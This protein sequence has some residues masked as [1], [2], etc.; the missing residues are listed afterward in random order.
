M[1]RRLDALAC[2]ALSAAALAGCGSAAHHGAPL[3]MLGAR[4]VGGWPTLGAGGRGIT[5]RFIE[6]TRLGVGLALRNRS[7]RSVTVVDVRTLE[8]PRTI[9]H[10]I[11]TRLVRWDPPSCPP[12]VRG[13]IGDVFSRSS[14]GAVRPVP[15]T[16]PPGKDVGVQ[17]N[18]RLGSCR[19]V[20]RASFAAA[21]AVVVDYRV[22]RGTLRRETLPL[23]SARLSVRMPQPGDCARRPHSH[24]LIRGRFATSSDSTEPGSDGDS[25]RRTARGGLR[26]RSRLYVNGQAPAF[27]IWIRLP[28]LRGR[29]TYRSAQVRAVVATGLRGRTVFRAARSLVTVT[30]TGA[31]TFGGRLHAGFTDR[32][33]LPFRAYGAWRCTTRWK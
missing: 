15:V 8:P 30:H 2:V 21:R 1:T 29:G 33:G 31:T 16:A 3:V 14:Y 25:C 6:R 20:P 24:I 22:G 11:G 17:L 32:R 7:R 13:C 23:G 26:F 4:A 10:Q 12:H 9:V 18:F 28:R 27:R 5:L 19:D